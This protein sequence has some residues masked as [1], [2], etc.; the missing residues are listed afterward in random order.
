MTDTEKETQPAR[1]RK[2]GALEYIA[3]LLGAAL[4]LLAVSLLLKHS[5]PQENTPVDPPA[6][7][8]ELEQNGAHS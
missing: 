8:G 3:I 1:R 7:A 2:S 4:V 5:A 6:I